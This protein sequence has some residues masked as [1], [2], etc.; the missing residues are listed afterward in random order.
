[1]LNKPTD[2]EDQLT[3]MRQAFI[4]GLP[5]RIAEIDSL[6]AAIGNSLTTATN[7]RKITELRML[8]HKL[9]GAGGTFGHVAVGDA[10][11]WAEQACDA[12]I[13]GEAEPTADQW[14]QVEARLEKLRRAADNAVAAAKGK[15]SA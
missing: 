2:F 12:I 14:K 1:M 6:A 4:D 5:G 15:K 9:S 13:A 8:I 3:A 11:A 10:A 7:L